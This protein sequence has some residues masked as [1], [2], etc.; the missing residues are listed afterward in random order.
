LEMRQKTLRTTRAQ[1]HSFDNHSP[2]AIP[3]AN[4]SLLETL[5]NLQVQ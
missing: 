1:Q 5:W 4:L 2:V 3:F